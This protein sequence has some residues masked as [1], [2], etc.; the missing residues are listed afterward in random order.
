MTVSCRNSALHYIRN[1]SASTVHMTVFWISNQ[2]ICCDVTIVQKRIFKSNWKL[3]C[4]VS[5]PNHYLKLNHHTCF[6]CDLHPSCYWEFSVAGLNP[7]TSRCTML[8]ASCL[9]RQVS[10]L[11]VRPVCVQSWCDSRDTGADLQVCS[12]NR[13][14]RYSHWNTSCQ[15]PGMFTQLILLELL[16]QC[17]NES[18][19]ACSCS[20]YYH[21]VT[22]SLEN[23]DKSGS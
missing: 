8:R 18:A 20:S 12:C 5:D 21:M 7:W 2:A 15:S 10:G 23:V 9:C 11:S 17:C 6:N 16:Y 14:P 22:T 4:S 1:S 19:D 3:N 13:E